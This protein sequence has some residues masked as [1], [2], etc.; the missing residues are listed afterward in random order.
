MRRRTP[1]PIIVPNS[2]QGLK[3]NYASR[4]QEIFGG[5]HDGSAGDHAHSLL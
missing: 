5:P 2:Q 1:L 4:V 3:N